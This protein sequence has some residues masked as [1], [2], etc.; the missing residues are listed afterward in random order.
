M[1][2]KTGNENCSLKNHQQQ[3]NDSPPM[4]NLEFLKCLKI[5]FK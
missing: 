1:I 2:I 5:I 4:I 3:K